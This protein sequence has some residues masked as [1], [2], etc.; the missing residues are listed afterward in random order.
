MTELSH[1]IL[2]EYQVRK[3]TLQKT[4]FITFL[5]EYFP[6][7][8][9]ETVGLIKSRNLIVGDIKNAKIILA[10]HY[11]TCAR[12]IVPNFITPKNPIL[13]IAYSFVILIPMMILVMGMNMLFGL[14]T[15]DFT[16]HYLISVAA[17]F[18]L[19]YVMV[20]GP[21][22]KHTANDNTSGVIMLCEM[23][24]TLS[25]EELQKTAIVFF[26]NEE[27]GLVGSTGFRKLH[28]ADM[29]NKLLINFDCISDGDNILV[30]VSKSARKNYNTTINEAFV[31]ESQKKILL[32]ESEKTYYPS[33]QAGYPN[34]I[35]IAALRKNKI[36]GYYM[37]R[38]HTDKDTV[39]DESNIDTIGSCIKKLI[40][41]L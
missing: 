15:D 40:N 25:P 30:A 1:K 14:I 12:M 21:A 5:Q 41:L 23:L 3:T 17:F 39:F 10:A 28:K 22:N 31:I 13:A 27:I 35:A 38:I 9:V 7:L 36:L 6:Q 19:M 20:A 33:D 24:Q 32:T 4:K 11:D 2:A 37:D 26:D 16:I 29:T 18:A 8:Q 34:H